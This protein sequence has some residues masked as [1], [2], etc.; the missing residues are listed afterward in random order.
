[1]F[2]AKA[3]QAILPDATVDGWAFDVEMLAIARAK[4]L[5]IVE[6]PIEWHYRNESRLSVGRD[7]F[8]MLREILAIRSRANDGT[9]S[10][11]NP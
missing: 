7:G 8:R 9:Y 2:T 3:V 10:R 4:D 6:V 5:R 1:M 11:V